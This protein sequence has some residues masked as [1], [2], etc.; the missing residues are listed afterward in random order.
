MLHNRKEI[1]TVEKLENGFQQ[2][3]IKKFSIDYLKQIKTVF[4]AAYSYSWENKVGKYGNAL[5]D[6]ELHISVN[7][8]YMSDTIM[9]MGGNGVADGKNVVSKKKAAILESVFVCLQQ[10]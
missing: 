4:P 9:Q 10:L 2:S 7:T 6:F 5:P 8:N 1:I 3:S